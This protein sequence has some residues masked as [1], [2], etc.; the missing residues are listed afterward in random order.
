MENAKYKDNQDFFDNSTTNEKIR[1]ISNNIEEWQI[2]PTRRWQFICSNTKEWMEDRWPWYIFK[3]KVEDKN[4]KV[5]WYQICVSTDMD[6]LVKRAYYKLNAYI[7]KNIYI[8]PKKEN[9]TN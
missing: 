7:E 2:I 9:D 3:A 5:K 4:W 1:I 8:Q 6:E